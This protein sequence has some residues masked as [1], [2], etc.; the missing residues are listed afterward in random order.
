[1]VCTKSLRNAYRSLCSLETEEQE[2]GNVFSSFLYSSLRW[3]SSL[4]RNKLCKWLRIDYTARKRSMHCRREQTG[5]VC[6]VKLSLWLATTAPHN[7]NVEHEAAA[8]KWGKESLPHRK[9]LRRYSRR[10]KE[11]SKFQREVFI[12]QTV[13][14]HKETFDVNIVQHHRNKDPEERIRQKNFRS[15]DHVSCYGR[16][17]EV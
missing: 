2:P 15:S 8:G 6:F 14:L 17:K 5:A 1:M 3:V 4:K 13:P 9:Q 10:R 7:D 12:F 16:K 11:S